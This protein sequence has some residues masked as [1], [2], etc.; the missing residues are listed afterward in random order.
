MGR[1]GIEGVIFFLFLPLLSFAFDC[2]YDY[3]VWNTRTRSSVGPFRVQKWKAELSPEEK[4][5]LGCTICNEDQREISVSGVKVKVC[6]HLA[7]KITSLL[8][9][10]QIK[11]L[12]GYRTSKSRGPVDNRGLRTQFSNHA[13]GVAI[14]VNENSNGLYNNCLNWGPG[15]VLTKGGP[16][17]PGQDPLSLTATSPVVQ[18]F[19]REGFHWGGEIESVQK[20]FM[21]FSPDGF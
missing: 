13:Y 2:H 17:R 19:K 8:N 7:G 10:A 15:C 11:T 5:P 16:Y 1:S 4:G 21:H 6:T 14:D 3:T 18:L 12:V 9:R 20:D